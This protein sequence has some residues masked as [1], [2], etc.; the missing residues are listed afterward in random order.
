MILL[1]L[2]VAQKASKIVFLA[3]FSSLSSVFQKRID[4]YFFANV[5]SVATQEPYDQD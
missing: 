4:K 1:R 5:L 2:R 3:F